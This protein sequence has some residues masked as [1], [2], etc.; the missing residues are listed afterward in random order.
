MQFEKIC[1]IKRPIFLNTT[2]TWKYPDKALKRAAELTVSPAIGR[3]K[4]TLE[5]SDVTEL[6]M[7]IENPEGAKFKPLKEL[8]EKI[9]KTILSF[10]I[11]SKYIFIKSS[12]KG[13]HVHVFMVGIRGDLQYIQMVS[14]ITNKTITKH[15]KK[16]H[17]FQKSIEH[18]LG[19][20]TRSKVEKTRIREFGGRNKKHYC[21]LISLEELKKKRI[22]PTIKKAENVVYPEI[23]LF[24]VTTDF[25]HKI[26]ESETEVW[27]KPVGTSKDT[28]FELDGEIENLY[29]C[30][31]IAK[32]VKRAKTKHHLTHPERLFILQE[33]SYFS[34]EG[35][36]EVHKI[37]SNCGDY[38][39]DYTQKMIDDLMKVGRKPITCKWARE[40]ISCPADCKGS[41]GT[42]PI[43]FAF[44]SITLERLFKT[45]TKWLYLKD[46]NG[47]E[48]ME[49]IE[50]PLA[51]AI[52]RDMRG[53]E[54]LWLL[55]VAAA[56]GIKTTIITALGKYKVYAIDDLTEHTFVSGMVYKEGSKRVKI[57]GHLKNMD[58]KILTIKDFSQI[59][60]S[61]YEK[62]VKI[63]GQ[64]RNIYDGYIDQP[65][66]SM[67]EKI[68]I[69]AKIGL[70]IGCTPSID[71]YHTLIVSLGERY[72]KIRPK[73]DKRAAG[74][75]A[76]KMRGKEVKMTQ[77]LQR[78]TNRFL[79]NLT[80][81]SP[82]MSEELE[83]KIL[84]LTMFIVQARTPTP[85][86]SEKFSDFEV[87]PEFPTR[88]SKQLAKLA[89]SLAVIRGKKNVTE[90]EFNTVKRVA[91]DTLPVKVYRILQY[92]YAQN[93]PKL[94]DDIANGANI[95]RWT[96]NRKLKG[97]DGIGQLVTYDDLGAGWALHPWS[98]QLLNRIHGNLMESK[99]VV[100]SIKSKY[101]N[102]EKMNLT[103]YTST[104]SSA[105][106]END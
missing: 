81:Y 31:L 23:K 91:F 89:E 40:M 88:L 13:F 34:E 57:I 93:E 63:F 38:D 2:D 73:I 67:K 4:L 100:K 104:D 101:N 71:N 50:V 51:C 12:G 28:D 80:F 10:N 54:K 53:E 20:D 11:P 84:D 24:Q 9:Y 102:Q 83:D 70:I 59:L 79:R 97:L 49:I 82:L 37:I 21:S 69:E 85:P 6:W 94:I 26:H 74:K 5:N 96:T 99:K 48:D 61:S 36:Q 76:L 1:G 25:I 56:G 15:G 29:K 17:L 95:S 33:F 14:A 8:V 72:L 39:K 66:G 75:H 60:S 98:R 47:K 106:H 58:G 3:Q 90:Q 30:P 105:H 22:Y 7:D 41:G 27:T 68:H 92:L 103:D 55:I 42:S 52:D 64:L 16:I 32:L 65:F 87:E 86:Q 18:S 46:K 19:I 35:Q 78:K 77:E 43:K 62:R 45:Y 44:S